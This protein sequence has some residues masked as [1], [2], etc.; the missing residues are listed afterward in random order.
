MPKKILSVKKG[1]FPKPFER[2][3]LLNTDSSPIFRP[4]SPTLPQRRHVHKPNNQI[5]GNKPVEVGYELSCVGL[6]GRR[7]LHGAGEPPW[8]P[9]L[10]MRLIPCGEN[11]N[12][13]TARQVSDLLDN[14]ELPFHKE[15]TVN[16]L[17]SN[18]SSPEYI[19]DTSPHASLVNV[20]RLASN[21]NVWRALGPEEQS[22]RRAGNGD[23]RGATAVYGE[24]AYKLSESG[25][26]GLPCDREERFGVKLASGKCCEAVVSIWEDM[27]LRSKRGKKM[28]DKPFRL[29]RVSLLDAE[30]GQPL[31]K[32]ELWLGGWGERRK[33]LSG[34]EIYWC[35]R[36]RYDIEH[37]FRYGKQKLLLDKFQTPDEGHL[38]NWLEV[39][40]LAYWLLWSAAGQAGQNSR[41][42]Q[43]YDKNLKKRQK[44]NLKP[45]PSQVQQQMAGIILGFEQD[46]FL[47]KLQIKGKGRQPG[48]TFEKRQ[49]HQ[50][51][52]K[53]KRQTKRA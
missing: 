18:Y 36:N 48:Q 19:A 9:P 8:N 2:F 33:E 32:R 14:R 3:W 39:V 28:K 49:H 45:S 47:P 43:K 20:I 10:S 34:E 15:L 40:S 52:K 51:L 17:D 23:K 42:W 7:P 53:Q 29:V 38:Q 41:K 31:F 26:W 1:L 25:Q 4:H 30:T 12:S 44:F 13:F 22:R 5:A 24:E 46:P 37:F 11:R 50:V 6:S 21:R 35:Y 27:L 16:A